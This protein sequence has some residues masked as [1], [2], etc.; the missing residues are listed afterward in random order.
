MWNTWGVRRFW[1]PK[2]AEIINFC[3]FTGPKKASPW[4][5]HQ[6]FSFYVLFDPQT[7]I[8][9]ENIHGK[10]MASLNNPIER[11]DFLTFHHF[12]PRPVILREVTIR[13]PLGAG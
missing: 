10:V 12:G 7:F 5:F 4:G 6:F 13:E 1:L 11:C 3:I 8:I 2:M 9:N